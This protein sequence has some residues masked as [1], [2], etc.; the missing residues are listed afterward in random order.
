M[1]H[2]DEIHGDIR[3]DDLAVALLNTPQLQRLGR[4]YQLGFGHLVYRGG[5]HSRLSHAMGTYF[6]ALSLARALQRNYENHRV[7]PRGAIEAWEFLPVSAGRNP[8]TLDPRDPKDRVKLQDRWTVLR[9]LVSWAA[10]LHDLGHVPLGHTL[11]DEF[12]DIYERHDSIT[13]RRLRHLW[14]DPTWQIREVLENTTLYP[15][16]FKQAG[17]ESGSSVYDTVLLICTWKEEVADDGART[18]FE[19]ILQKH[20]EDSDPGM[21]PE[22]LNAMKRV[23]GSLFHPYMADLVANTISADYLD[24]LRRDPHNLGLDVLR[25]GRITSR[26]WIGRD[27]HGQSRMALSLV[28]RRGKPR[29]DTCTGVVELVRQRFRFAEIVYYHKT[30]V[31]ASA[32]LAKAFHLLEKPPEV[33]ESVRQLPTLA[34]AEKRVNAVIHASDRKRRS[35]L[36]DLIADCTPTS[37]LDPEVGD[38]GLDALLRNQAFGQLRKAVKE[39]DSEKALKAIRGITLLDALARR[40]LYKTVFTITADSFPKLKGYGDEEAQE[41]E[42]SDFIDELRRNSSVREE[43]E[44][45]MVAAAEWDECSI[46]LYVPGRKSQAKGIET[47]A[48]SNGPVRT[49]KNHPAVRHEVANLS[50]KYKELWRCIILVHPDRAND[51]IGLSKAIDA[52]VANRFPES[53]LVDSGVIKALQDGAWFQYLKPRLRPAAEVFLEL[54]EGEVGESGWETFKEYGMKNDS[55]SSRQH[56]LGAALAYE[57]K[58]GGSRPAGAIELVLGKWKDPAVLESKIDELVEASGSRA[59][60]LDEEARVREL[61]QAIHMLA[62]ELDPRWSPPSGSGA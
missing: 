53:D 5:N 42:L 9:H 7:Y 21:A 26:F 1:I 62:A 49:L 14:S 39:K 10:L 16:A 29:L 60:D 12:D 46:L 25:D 58:S 59:G 11:E 38:E 18:M 47:G 54:I 50:R 27:R 44:R 4:V 48:L 36:E 31:A 2:R 35:M 43:L 13:S 3:Y 61:R 57:L 24:Y 30:K 55:C 8:T 20:L 40:E 56:G 41:D 17:I 45:E 15:E 22:L 6:T 32:M 51:A 34:N 23:N 33:P 19:Q 28:D 37:L 52:F